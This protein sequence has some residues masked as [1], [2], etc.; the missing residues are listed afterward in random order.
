VHY[1]T[2]RTT[3][4]FYGAA[5]VKMESMPAARR[6]VQRAADGSITLTSRR[7]RVGFAPLKEGDKWPP[8][9]LTESERPPIPVANISHFVSML[10]QELHAKGSKTVSTVEALGT[11]D[12]VGFYFSSSSCPP[13]VAFTP[14]L[15]KAYE[16]INQG[17]VRFEVI[18]VSS[19]DD[20]DAF[21][22][23]RKKMP[24]LSMSF[25]AA[26]ARES[27]ATKCNVRSLPQLVLLNRH[28]D[29]VAEDAG[30]Q[31]EEDLRGDFVAALCS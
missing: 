24:W 10:G 27:L 8:S 30:A 13:C 25:E 2:D 18:F 12:V 16:S 6:A 1:I 28:G 15:A 23:Y 3:G 29:V 20:A 4:L 26:N 17:K 5:F 9:G 21:E 31:F 19:D 11:T 22:S 7:L 14:K